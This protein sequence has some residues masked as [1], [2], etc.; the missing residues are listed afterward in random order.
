MNG[1]GG[2]GQKRTHDQMMM[3]KQSLT[4]DPRGEVYV[5]G[6][7][8]R[9]GKSG[10]FDEK[11]ILVRNFSEKFRIPARRYESFRKNSVSQ[12]PAENLDFSR[13]YQKFRSRIPVAKFSDTAYAQREENRYAHP[14]QLLFV[15]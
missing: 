9:G 12:N 14:V 6:Q 1:E 3:G 13:I 2:A 15:E 5:H 11:N 7:I 4:Y 8:F 10:F